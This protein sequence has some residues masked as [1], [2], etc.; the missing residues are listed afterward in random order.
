[1]M[2]LTPLADGQL[3][4]ARCAAHPIA[5]YTS[6]NG[7][8]REIITHTLRHNTELHPRGQHREELR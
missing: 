3:L 2:T 1:M 6:V 5:N 8:H 4:A 7:P